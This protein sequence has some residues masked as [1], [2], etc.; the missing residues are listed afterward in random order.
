MGPY[1]KTLKGYLY[2]LNMEIVEEAFENSRIIVLTGHGNKGRFIFCDNDPDDPDNPLI[3]EETTGSGDPDEPSDPPQ[4]GFTAA[5]ITTFQSDDYFAYAE[6][7]IFGS[8]FSGASDEDN[9]L[10]LVD[11][12]YNGRDIDIVIGFSDEL[13]SR[14]FSV[15]QYLFFNEYQKYKNSN[16]HNTPIAQIAAEVYRE[17]YENQLYYSVTTDLSH[18]MKDGIVVVKTDLY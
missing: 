16:N 13:N 8:C 6:V 4:R 11:A 5:E 3:P 14:A 15:F 7:V 17:I 9:P 18:Q 1:E 12:A 10:S 2:E